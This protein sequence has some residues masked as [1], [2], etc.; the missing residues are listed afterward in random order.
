MNCR[1]CQKYLAAYLDSELPHNDASRVSEHINSCLSCRERVHELEALASSLETLPVQEVPNG[2]EYRIMT[3]AASEF[4][5][6]PKRTAPYWPSNLFSCHW[7]DQAATTAALVIG[8]FLGGM[9]GW[10]GYERNDSHS[11]SAATEQELD[12]VVTASM[13]AVPRGSIEAAV[14]AMLDNRGDY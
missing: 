7:F 11:L 9:L 6:S 8:L 1:T 12:R 3:Q 4:F 14:L 13:T 2:L 5:D 10:S